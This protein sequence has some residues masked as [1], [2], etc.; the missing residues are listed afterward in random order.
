[1]NKTRAIESFNNIAEKIIHP[2]VI[3]VERNIL[4]AVMINENSIITVVKY[5]KPSHFSDSKHQFIYKACLSLFDANSLIDKTCLLYTSCKG[6]Y[7][8]LSEKLLK[9]IQEILNDKYLSLQL[10]GF[11]GLLTTEKNLMETFKLKDH[12]VES[13]NIQ[14]LR[15]ESFKKFPIEC[16][17]LPD[18]T[19]MLYKH[20]F[21]NLLTDEIVREDLRT[22]GRTKLLPENQYKFW[23]IPINIA[24][25]DDFLPERTMQVL[26]PPI[27]V[28]A[29][30][31]QLNESK[32]DE[33]DKLF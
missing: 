20:I 26:I 9:V 15:I 14:C 27:D 33:S 4:A 10:F 28:E 23:V 7:K 24:S 31:K 18:E 29:L 13:F 6:V 16:E 12:W 30:E 1:M 25:K 3:D 32:V 8:M 2:A 21:K 11:N 17:V 19:P 22:L 5:L